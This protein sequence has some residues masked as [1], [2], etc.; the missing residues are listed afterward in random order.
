MHS[1]EQLTLLIPPPHHEQS[2]AQMDAS[3]PVYDGVLYT[4]EWKGVTN[5]IDPK[6]LLWACHHA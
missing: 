5:T 6:F 1:R 2:M 3:I 4:A